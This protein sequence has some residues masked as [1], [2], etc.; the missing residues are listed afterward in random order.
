MS[1]APF[2]PPDAPPRSEDELLARADALAGRRFAWIAAGLGRAVPDDLTRHKGW[3]GQL[4]EHALGGAAGS[5]AGP[6]FPRL[7][8]ELKTIPVDAQGVPRETTFV[9]TA[10][11]RELGD[12]PWGDS[13]VR[14]KLARVLWV[15]VEAAPDIPLARRRVG[16]PYLWSPSPEEDAALAADWD[17][18]SGLVADGFVES[19]TAHRGAWLQIRPKAANSRKRTW[20]ED[21][22]G[23]LVR[24]LPR[25]FYLRRDFTARLLARHFIVAR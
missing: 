3:V 8:I 13:P 11:L 14:K 9:C 6:D 4:V 21:D 22:D 20:A 19:I 23:D 25:G 18:L 2:V 1:A 12:Q 24:T 15:P 17:E 7:G 10:T 16:A 5:S